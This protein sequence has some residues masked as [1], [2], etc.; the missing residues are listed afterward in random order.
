[1]SNE[2]GLACHMCGRIIPTKNCA[3]GFT[4]YCSTDCQKNHWPTHKVDIDH[5]ALQT[6]KGKAKLRLL[7]IFQRHYNHLLRTALYN[8]EQCNSYSALKWYATKLEL[9]KEEYYL[10]YEI[11]DEKINK[12]Q[13]KDIW[14][15]FVLSLMLHCPSKSAGSSPTYRWV[16]PAG[17]VTLSLSPK[18]P[19]CANHM[20]TPNMH[21]K[22]NMWIQMSISSISSISST[23][24]EAWFRIELHEGLTSE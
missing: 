9:P 4:R 17:K 10:R 18:T 21:A 6:K 5:K 24:S 14:Q 11:H 12:K 2:K 16:A 15:R 1:M 23:D 8:V 22:A 3:C 7:M 19:E 13:I 20:G